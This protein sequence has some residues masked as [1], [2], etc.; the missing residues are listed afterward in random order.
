MVA[1][2]GRGKSKGGGLLSL[3]LDS[4]RINGQRTPVDSDT[5]SRELK[6]KG[7]RTAV[8]GGGGAGV[9]ALIGGLAGGGKGA[10]IGGLAGGGAGTAAGAYT[11][12]QLMIVGA[13]SRLT[14]RLANSVTAR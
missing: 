7:K 1:A 4:L 13:V 8:F 6:G 14:F 3:K 10:L 2:N 9:G 5:W 11:G 12:H